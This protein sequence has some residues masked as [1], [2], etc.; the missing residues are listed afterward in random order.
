MRV[1]GN[2]IEL[3]IKGGN[4]APERVEGEAGAIDIVFGEGIAK[5]LEPYVAGARESCGAAN[6]C[7]D[8]AVKKSSVS[9]PD[10]YRGDI[11]QD[12]PGEQIPTVVL[13]PTCS[14]VG[15]FE[16]EEFVSGAVTGLIAILKSA[17]RASESGEMKAK[18]IMVTA[19]E[20]ISQIRQEAEL[21]EDGVR[22]LATQNA[23]QIREAEFAPIRQSLAN[24]GPKPN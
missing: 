14:K 24:M 9:L 18:T 4:D 16:C 8:V 7:F 6:C 20:D 17:Q 12:E 13:E 10:T 15:R 2:V 22:I 3:G 21:R 19:A 5:A 23:Q 1:N 11:A